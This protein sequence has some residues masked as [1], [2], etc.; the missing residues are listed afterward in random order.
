MHCGQVRLCVKA[1]KLSLDVVGTVCNDDERLLRW[2]ATRARKR[3][4]SGSSPD[5]TA[6]VSTAKV[7]SACHVNAHNTAT[8]TSQLL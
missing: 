4:V 3:T 8:A 2:P 1:V 5:F 7:N 6:S